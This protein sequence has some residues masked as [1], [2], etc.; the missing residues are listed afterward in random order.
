MSA[1]DPCGPC[2]LCCRSY[3]VPLFGHDL[4]R[5]HSQLHLPPESIAFIAEQ[6]TPD[7]LG[8]L[9]EAGG[10]THGVALLKK[11]PIVATQPCIFLDDAPNGHTRCGIYANRPV[12]CQ[13]YPM[14]KFGPR[15]YQ[16]EATLCPPDSWSDEDTLA[17]HWR[18]N[19][20][21]LRMYRDIYVEVVARWNAAVA[22]WKPPAM[23]PA[24]VFCDYLL[25]VYDQI[26]VA[27]ESLEPDLRR[28]ILL[29]WAQV[30]RIDDSRVDDR[31][32][33]VARAHEPP[34]IAHFRRV[35]DVI[36]S[37]F[38]DL[39]PLPFQNILVESKPAKN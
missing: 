19:L 35:R 39:V 36:D 14:S 6:E 38:P 3:L 12:T 2:G 24:S 37:F 5:I 22:R 34:W 20:Q 17:P 10:P 28:R 8:F 15:V 9:L 13:T 1:K 4:W 18:E 26:A 30:D 31:E 21:R 25:R 27:E 11:E 23:L 33:T 32:V 29:G 7:A 16:R